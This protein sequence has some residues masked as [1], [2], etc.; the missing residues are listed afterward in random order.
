MSAGVGP[1]GSMGGGDT[2]AALKSGSIRGST[3]RLK[4]ATRLLEGSFY[5]EMFKA[6]RE[7]VPDDGEVTGGTGGAMFTSMLDGHMAEEAA[8]RSSDGLG[9]ALYAHFAKALD[10]SA[11]D[12]PGSAGAPGP[13]ADAG[14]SGAGAAGASTR[15]EGER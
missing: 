2:L 4:A 9:A 11:P 14:V 10:A 8:L 13:A 3:A 1:V 12:A 5:E 15:A 7:T 6:M